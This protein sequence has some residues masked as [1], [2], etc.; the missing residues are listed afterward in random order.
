[1]QGIVPIYVKPADLWVNLQEIGDSDL[2]R[3]QRLVDLASQV[4]R[5]SSSFTLL[6][7]PY[8]RFMCVPSSYDKTNEPNKGFRNTR[9]FEKETLKGG[10]RVFEN[11]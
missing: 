10:L 2:V 11:R 3:L 8:A 7:S 6:L 4:S 1:M 9:V 5:S